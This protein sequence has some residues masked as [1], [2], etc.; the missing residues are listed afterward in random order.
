MPRTLDTG[1]LENAQ[2]APAIVHDAVVSVESSAWL[3]LYFDKVNLPAGGILRLTSARDGDVQELNAAE[4][5]MWNNTS[6]YFNGDT[7]TL[8]LLAAPGTRDN[9]V[10]LR[11]VATQIVTQRGPCAGDDCGICGSDDRVPSAELWSGRLMPVGCTASVYNTS[12][13][14]VSAGH[15]ASSGL[16]IQFSPQP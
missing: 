12:S 3:R 16:V 4:L 14:V 9:R 10:V 7:V 15:C 8:E 2:D 5:V 1:V 13:C 11:E 6:A